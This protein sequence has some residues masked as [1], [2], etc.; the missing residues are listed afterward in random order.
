MPYEWPL[1]E[2]VVERFWEKVRTGRGR[3]CWLWQACLNH[4]GYGMIRNGPR[5]MSLAHRLSWAIHF[6]DPGSNQVLHRCD[7]RECVN[8]AHLYLGTNADNMRDKVER[9]RSSYPRPDR[10]GQKHPLAKLTDRQVRAIRRRARGRRGEGRDLASE[11]GVSRATICN[12]L[13]RK[14]WQ[15]V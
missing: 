8:P 6:G 4:S 10:Q 14:S 7:N 3:S 2:G 12:I 9:G 1:H 11:F 5:G 15:S 13:K